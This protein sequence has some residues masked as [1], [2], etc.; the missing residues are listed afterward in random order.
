MTTYLL[1]RL[2]LMVPTFL[3]I[4][5]VIWLVMALSP[6]KPTGA[7]GGGEMGADPAQMDPNRDESE[8]IFREQFALNR[9]VLWNGWTRLGE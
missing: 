1:R 6:G 4:S 9:P 2:L 7:G 8:R 5:V 3:G